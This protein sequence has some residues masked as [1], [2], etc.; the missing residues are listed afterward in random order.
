MSTPITMQ[1][2]QALRDAIRTALAPVAI[3]IEQEIQVLADGVLDEAGDQPE[4]VRFPAVGITIA[5]C[6]P[7]GHRSAFREYPVV[8]KV[9]TSFGTDPRQQGLY[10]IGEQIGEYFAGAPY[11]TGS[12]YQTTG[13]TFG[14]PA[15]REK[16][17]EAS[18]QQ[19][20]W[21]LTAHVQKTE[22]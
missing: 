17:E 14:G 18:I 1:L 5:E 21:R 3:E 11:V 15:T 10:T 20:E 6:S 4:R 12:G 16:D 9:Q 13:W 2:A 22:A 8:V 7:D 19:M